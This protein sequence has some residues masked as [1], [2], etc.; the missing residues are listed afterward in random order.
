LVIFKREVLRILTAMQQQVHPQTRLFG[1]LFLDIDGGHIRIELVHAWSRT[2][3]SEQVVFGKVKVQ[4]I[5]QIDKPAVM[6]Q[7]FGTLGTGW[8]RRSRFN[9][10]CTGL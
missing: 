8:L 7:R 1:Y 9:R 6:P 3:I 4:R 10:A 5:A 2:A